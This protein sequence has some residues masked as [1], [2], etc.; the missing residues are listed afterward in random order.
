MFCIW[1]RLHGGNPKARL[2]RPCTYCREAGSLLMWSMNRRR[3]RMWLLER[4]RKG[5]TPASPRY[6]GCQTHMWSRS[7]WR[8][9]KYWKGNISPITVR[10]V[11]ERVKIT[12]HTIEIVSRLI[13]PGK[14]IKNKQMRDGSSL[15]GIS[16]RILLKDRNPLQRSLGIFSDRETS[17]I[18]PK[19]LA[20]AHLVSSFPY[21]PLNTSAG[22][23]NRR[24]TMNAKDL[25]LSGLSG[26]QWFDKLCQ[27]P[28]WYTERDIVVRR[29]GIPI[30]N[31]IRSVE[32]KKLPEIQK[33]SS[34]RE[35]WWIA[36]MLGWWKAQKLTQPFCSFGA[37]RQGD[38]LSR[39]SKDTKVTSIVYSINARS[40][41]W[42]E[43][44][45]VMKCS[46]RK[47]IEMSLTKADV[48]NCRQRKWCWRMQLRKSRPHW[49]RR[50]WKTQSVKHKGWMKETIVLLFSELCENTWSDFSN[51]SNDFNISKS[52]ISW[53]SHRHQRR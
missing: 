3:H 28:P 48:A 16:I 10:F 9:S 47:I 40:M 45:I 32:R 20:S 30:S 26:S 34:P 41:I 21:R 36:T 46:N 38:K 15:Q 42:N 27:Q 8:C 49:N 4:T 37:R 44:L 29:R 5:E 51:R 33:S 24:V 14:G 17:W 11:L 39:R 23:T 31:W 25:A 43:L 12:Y 18:L 35:L 19:A 7:I 6:I 50:E 52:C 1:F 22:K 13:N 53:H 2:G